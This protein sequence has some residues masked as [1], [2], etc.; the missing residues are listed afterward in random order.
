MNFSESEFTKLLRACDCLDNE[1]KGKMLKHLVGKH[2][3]AS[4]LFEVCDRLSK[5]EKAKLLKHLI[6]RDTDLSV[7][8]GSSSFNANANT[9]YQIGISDKEQ[10]S[11]V[12][13]AIANFIED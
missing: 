4:V 12:L 1:E 7:A 3:S 10:I 11:D 5:E 8:I 9:V 2:T 6:S 13:R